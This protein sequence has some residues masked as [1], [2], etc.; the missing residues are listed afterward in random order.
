MRL[1]WFP[2]TWESSSTSHITSAM[3]AFHPDPGETP[4]AATSAR[5]QSEHDRADPMRRILRDATRGDHRS[6]D[7]QSPPS[8]LPIAPA[9]ACFSAIHH[10]ALSHLAGRWRAQ[11]Q[12]DFSGLL[13]CLAED[14]RALGSLVGFPGTPERQRADSLRQWGIAYVIRGSRLGGAVLRQRVPAAI[15]PPT[16]PTSRP[17][18]GLNS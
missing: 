15:P 18:P 10:A 3:S 11:D 4:V 7:Q 17:S 16:S 5:L 6:I 8:I 13:H 2:D 12:A 14:L 1:R 9:I